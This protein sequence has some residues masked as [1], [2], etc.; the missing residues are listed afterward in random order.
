MKR[1]SKCLQEYPET[2]EFFYK[3]KYGLNSQCIACR[4]AYLRDYYK[5]HS[6]EIKSHA[7]EWAKGNHD[8]RLAIQRRYRESNRDLLRDKSRQY[9]RLNWRRL[10]PDRE[11]LRRRHKAWRDKNPGKYSHYSPGRNSIRRARL[12]GASGQYSAA[13]VIQKLFDQDGK[14]FWCGVDLD[15]NFHVDHVI[16]LSRGGSNGPENI[17]MTCPSCNLSKGSKT[18]DEFLRFKSRNSTTRNL[19]SD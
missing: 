11:T 2:T 16:P 13:D 7:A 12:R 5:A 19:T 17:A 10:A 8:K 1:C 18:P 14:C 6:E 3:T 4:K 9:M 15:G